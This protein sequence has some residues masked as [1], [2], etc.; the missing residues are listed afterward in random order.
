MSKNDNIHCMIPATFPREIIID[1]F[2]FIGSVSDNKFNHLTVWF[3]VKTSLGM[4]LLGCYEQSDILSRV[5][6]NKLGKHLISNCQIGKTH[7]RKIA[8]TYLNVL[9]LFYFNDTFKVF[10]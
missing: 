3:D 8:L 9:L 4:N 10:S 6:I 7:L 1:Y 2:T 5:I